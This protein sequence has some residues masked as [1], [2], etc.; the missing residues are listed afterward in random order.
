MEKCRRVGKQNK[1]VTLVIYVA[2]LL[3][4][5]LIP[6]IQQKFKLYFISGLT[7]FSAL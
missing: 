3:L 6:A 4:Y 7:L 1:L 5:L 2:A